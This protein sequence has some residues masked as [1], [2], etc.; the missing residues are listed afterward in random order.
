MSLP[1][2]LHTCRRTLGVSLACAVLL[3]GCSGEK[4]PVRLGYLGGLTGRTAD[5]GTGGRNGIQIAIDEVNSAGGIN[6]RKIELVLKDDSNDPEKAKQLV[7]ALID[8]K[9]DA[10]LGPMTS[11]VAAAVSP[12][13]TEAKI[14]MVGGSVTTNDLTGKDDL[15]FRTISASTVHAATMAEYLYTQRNVRKVN[16][17][18][19]LSNKAYSESWILNFERAFS[20]LG[21]Q[22]QRQVTYASSADTNFA[23]L[24]KA[25]L[26]GQPD[27]VILVT[28]A[29][30]AA[31]FA[32]QVRLLRGKALMVTSEWAGTGKLTEL[33][34]SNVEGYIVPQYLDPQSSSPEFL[35]FRELYRQRFQQDVGFPAVVAFNAAQV[36]I[37]GLREKMPGESLKQAVLRL[38]RFPGLQG[39]VVFDDTGDVQSRT[40]LTEIRNGQYLLVR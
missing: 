1:N 13:V 24:T 33:G 18:V 19:N 14:L 10:I 20:Q 7:Q 34:G 5:L 35:A 9:V 16:A 23:E 38:R 8:A 11:N 25:L 37:K 39:D 36:V 12:I 2:V 31:L 29:V 32:N 3:G 26:D 6:G 15:F 22:V 17:A 21:G 40:Y 28:N 4:P 27:A 30:D